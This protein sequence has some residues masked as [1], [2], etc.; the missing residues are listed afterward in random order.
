MRAHT[1]TET[2][3]GLK[4]L[5]LHVSFFS[6]KGISADESL[7]LSALCKNGEERDAKFPI[8]RSTVE[9]SLAL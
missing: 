4:E 7:G 2:R 5:T 3:L 9:F 6:Y 8:P 1:H